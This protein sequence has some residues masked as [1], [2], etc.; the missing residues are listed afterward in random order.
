MLY[1]F[2][3][4]RFQIIRSTLKSAVWHSS[5]KKTTWLFQLFRV[6]VKTRNLSNLLVR[7]PIT[8]SSCFVGFKV[9][10]HRVIKLTY[11]R[12]AHEIA[13]KS[14]P[15]SEN[16]GKISDRRLLQISVLLFNEIFLEMIF[17]IDKDYCWGKIMLVWQAFLF[18][19]D[20]NFVFN[21]SFWSASFV[22][23]IK[24]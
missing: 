23:D 11:S 1:I 9:K 22:K 19:F 21:F 15:S 10:N 4:K 5:Y 17:Q 14:R 8:K 6:A 7:A 2:S 16:V 20:K 13:N 18:D 12:L 24:E 3:E